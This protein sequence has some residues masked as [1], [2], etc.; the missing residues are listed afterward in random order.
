MSND[1]QCWE[2]MIEI[3]NAYHEDD[4][5]NA[6]NIHVEE[7]LAKHCKNAANI[8]VEEWLAKYCP[9]PGTPRTHLSIVRPTRGGK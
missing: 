6:A 1:N 5:M 2:L 9:H 8:H 3:R 4:E 7:W